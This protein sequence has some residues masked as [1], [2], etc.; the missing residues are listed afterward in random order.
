MKTFR[1]MGAAY[2]VGLVLIYLLVV[3]Q[4][5]SYFDAF[6]HHGTYPFNHHWCDAGS[7]FTQARNTR[8][9]A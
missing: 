1:D 4:F 7:C 2:A 8:Q 5:G 6:D 9:P 3:A